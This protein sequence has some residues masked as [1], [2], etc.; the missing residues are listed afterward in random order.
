[1]P[2]N[3]LSIL[4]WVALPVALLLAGVAT[5]FLGGAPETVDDREPTVLVSTEAT[6]ARVSKAALFDWPMVGAQATADGAAVATVQDLEAVKAGP[7]GTLLLVDHP[8]DR[9]GARIRWVDQRGSII[10]ESLAPPGSTLFTP[11]GSARDFAYVIAKQTG[12]S[13]QLVLNRGG[14]ESTFT[15]PM[16]LNSGGI[17]SIGDTVYVS[18]LTGTT[19]ME[20]STSHAEDALL[21]V[22][23]A[24]VQVSDEDA[25]NT[26]R[27]GTLLG[28]DGKLYQY[29]V[30]SVGIGAVESRE[31]RL[32]RLSDGDT[33]RI[34]DSAKLLG[35]D[36][37]G[38]AW[39]ALPPSALDRR[40]RFLAA[41]PSSDDRFSEVLVTGFDGKAIA[42]L[43]IPRT[44]KLAAVREPYALADGA[45]Y[46]V[47]QAGD[48][49]RIWQYQ[50]IDR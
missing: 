4:W 40:A 17:V 34:P 5:Y 8:G 30:D 45:L 6:D 28:R 9:A 23:R 39:L 12:P 19:D 21:P 32:K 31:G 50:V 35:V 43:S 13:E 22:V 10:E 29:S 1:M 20:T 15:V 36:K 48:N 47:T 11:L 14:V 46:A 26:G 33:L 37:Q 18:V 42:R 24:G 27:P 38:R 2:R 3:R 41:S 7:A 49:L 44:T 25:A 16:Q